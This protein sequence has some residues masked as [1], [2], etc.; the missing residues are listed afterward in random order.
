MATLIH[1]RVRDDVA[2]AVAVALAVRV[3]V[4][5][6]VAVAVAVDVR[7]AVEL[8]VLEALADPLAVPYHGSHTRVAQS[9]KYVQCISGVH[10]GQ[11][12]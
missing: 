4:L 9:E 6:R 11:L 10:S 8:D 3:V 5:V 7:V 2:L 12:V 1:G